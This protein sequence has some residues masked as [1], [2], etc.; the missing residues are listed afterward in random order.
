MASLLLIIITIIIIVAVIVLGPLVTRMLNVKINILLIG[1][2][3]TVL[4][5]LLVICLLIPS[6]ALKSP[7]NPGQAAEYLENDHTLSARIKAG[8]F[9]APEGCTQNTDTLDA[10]SG[11]ITVSTASDLLGM[12]FVGTKGVDAPD[13]GN[14]KIDVYSYVSSHV[15]FNDTYYDTQID[16]PIIS[17]AHNI[18]AINA[19]D[20]KRVDFYQFS[21]GYAI[22]Q[23]SGV[24]G[25]HWGG[26]SVTF[27][28]VVVL[29]PPGVTATGSGYQPLSEFDDYV[30]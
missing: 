17:L 25:S 14:Q 21:D 4:V 23:F 3:F 15:I 13:N 30:Y 16:P 27:L 28:T 10:S 8:N 7:A 2:Y 5:V 20:K 1:G 18:L 11:S 24:D 29:L 9:D 19:A 26:G 12:V 22:Q 6:S